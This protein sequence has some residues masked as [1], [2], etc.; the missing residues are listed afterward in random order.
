[1]DL[2]FDTDVKCKCNGACTNFKWFKN[3]LIMY[4]DTNLNNKSDEAKNKVVDINVISSNEQHLKFVKGAFFDVNGTYG[5]MIDD[6][7]YKETIVQ[8][9]YTP[10]LTSNL[11]DLNSAP[12][13]SEV[14]LTCSVTSLEE[15][16]DLI[17]K[18]NSFLLDCSSDSDTC[19][20]LE[21]STEDTDSF[22]I[23]QTLVIPFISTE[24]TGLYQC[25]V[26]D[27]FGNEATSAI[28]IEVYDNMPVILD[29][30][31]TSKQGLYQVS[32]NE[33]MLLEKSEL[34]LNCNH[35]G[36]QITWSLPNDKQEEGVNPLVIETIDANIDQGEYVC[37]VSNSLNKS[38]QS[39]ASIVIIQS[40][41]IKEPEIDEIEI[42]PPGSLLLTCD[43]IIDQRV[44]EFVYFQWSK[45]GVNLPVNQSELSIPQVSKEDS[46]DYK[47]SLESIHGFLNQVEEHWTVKIKQ[48]P[49]ILPTF[50]ASLPLLLGQNRTIFCYGNGIPTPSIEWSITDKSEEH[51]I[52]PRVVIPDELIF[53]SSAEIIVTEAGIYK[54]Q[55]SNEYNETFQ[56][57][58]IITVHPTSITENDFKND[59]II[60]ADAGSTI[61]L[62]CNVVIDPELGQFGT[63]IMWLKN[64]S[65]LTSVEGNGLLN[66]TIPYLSFREHAGSYACQVKTAV[67]TITTLQHLQV[68]TEAPKIKKPTESMKRVGKGDNVT[69]NCEVISGIPKPTIEW[70]FQNSTLTPSIN[71]SL[72]LKSVS[73]TSE[74]TYSCWAVNE[75]GSHKI[76]F[77][78]EV[79]YPPVLVEGPEDT[80]IKTLG[81]VIFPC[82]TKIDERIVDEV[83]IKWFYNDTIELSPNNSSQLILN[84][85]DKTDEGTYTCAISTPF[86]NLNLTA[87]LSVL[88]EP[89]TFISTEEN[90]RTIEGSTA[91]LSCQ[92][93]GMPLPKIYW[94]KHNSNITNDPSK[95]FWNERFGDL[96]VKDISQNDQGF[97]DCLA[98]NMYGT[99]ATKV[100]IEVVRKSMPSDDHTLARK[101][102]KN[103]HDDV[104]LKCG[105]SYDPR[106]EKE[107]RVQWFRLNRD[108]EKQ[109]VN[110]NML[111]SSTRSDLKYLKQ[112]GNSLLIQ[113]NLL[114]SIENKTVVSKEFRRLQPLF[115]Y[116]SFSVQ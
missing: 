84:G 2:T 56:G 91:N 50:P 10:E 62:D 82:L 108:N 27:E 28:D 22:S 80:E 112:L 52:Q 48:S 11:G 54:C 24:S 97:Y 96:T 51:L 73:N 29:L 111:L 78:L 59:S 23:T 83:D 12:V 109:L 7:I 8:L 106:L 99:I 53:E 101:V 16:V 37:T 75:Y 47:C 66:Y 26:M 90:V 21:K 79:I 74:G 42:E 20:I 1:M 68:I 71:D 69:L 14:I 25:S 98:T 95:F 89:P 55:A 32:S 87:K 77:D 110:L 18:L 41:R 9:P 107:T 114:K 65:I 46:G 67:D 116:V 104:V 17:W 64:G 61:T 102:V 88:G 36:T 57:I 58:E 100:K 72:E 19:Q 34:V 4:N 92:A 33:Y 103:V 45:D 49:T 86:G 43:A 76:Q 85:V 3:G 35:N 6:F 70:K 115:T 81:T 40:T 30:N 113:G 39:R 60:Q 93:N 44:A 13:G 15:N 5:C 31:V 94:Q 105:I 38:I 63:D